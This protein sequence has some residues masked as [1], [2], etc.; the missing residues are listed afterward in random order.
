M[1]EGFRVENDFREVLG[2][3]SKLER[4]TK[5]SLRKTL[6]E[7]ANDGKTAVQREVLASKGRS[8]KSGDA[9]RTTKTGET[10]TSRS[11][12][13]TTRQVHRSLRRRIADAVTVELPMSATRTEVDIKVK[14]SKLPVDFQG[15]AGA[16]D[17]RNGWRHPVFAGR[18][19]THGRSHTAVKRKQARYRKKATW[20]Q[21]WGHPYFRTVLVARKDDMAKRIEQEIRQ[22][23][24]REFGSK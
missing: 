20:V 19:P 21:Q 4:A 6:R 12:K 13:T 9:I 11:G 8:A 24:E 15:V 1:S 14:K 16:W 22:T 7:I 18:K 5:N 3:V 10:K 23:V 2:Q 17:S